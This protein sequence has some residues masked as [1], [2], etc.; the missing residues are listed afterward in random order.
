MDGH[1]L[2]KQI[3]YCWFGEKPLPDEAKRCIASWKKFFPD[4]EVKEW[5]EK[6]F[7]LNCCD[8]VKEA[9]KMKMWAFVSDYARFWI[10]Y[11]YGGLYFDTDVEVIRSFDDILSKGSFM[12]QEAGASFGVNSIGIAEVVVNPG[13]GIAATPGLQLYKEFLDCYDKLHFINDGVID[14]TTICIRATNILKK[15]GYDEKKEEVQNVAG[16]T[17]YPPEYFCPQNFNTGEMQVTENTYSIHHYAATWYTWIDKVVS[18]IERCDK[19]KH[20]TSYR[21][22][23]IVSFPFRVINKIK[24]IGV[25]KTVQAAKNKLRVDD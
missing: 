13:L 7:N 23:R 15:F 5:N 24:K 9:Y 10:L 2:P 12:G 25:R 4:Y 8:Y 20:P 17:I 3:H 16:I 14:T 21:F 1:I 18:G 6:N 19:E 11:N 22:R